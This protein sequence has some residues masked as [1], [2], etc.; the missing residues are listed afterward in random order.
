MANVFGNNSNR[1]C[2]GGNG[3][4]PAPRPSVVPATSVASNPNVFRGD[5]G[6]PEQI[7]PRD[8]YTRRE[9]DRYLSDKADLSSV[10]KREETYSSNEIDQLFSQL[11]LS[12]YAS[13]TY[14]D[15]SI[16]SQINA[17]NADLN[18]NYYTKTLV[19]SKSEVDSLVSSA[20]IGDAYISKNPE[21]LDDITLVPSVSDLSVSLVVRSSNDNAETQVQRWE[22]LSTDFVAAIYADG[23]AV[24]TNLLKV[25]ENVDIG[26]VSINAS[27][28]RVGGV[29]DPI[30]NLDAVNKSYMETWITGVIDHIAQ[31]KNENYLI[32]A[33]EY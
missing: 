10:Y 3:I 20:D 28:R 18:S 19:Y 15:S 1:N 23:K 6:T 32:D 9:I 14:V 33:L 7:N 26:D 5:S 13:I 25:G 27:E 16:S 30:D 4:L 17:I 29:A 21:T 31:D 24:F 8:F 2:S 11:N 12:S 22:N